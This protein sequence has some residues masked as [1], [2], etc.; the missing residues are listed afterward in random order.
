MV[1]LLL[2]EQT[3]SCL[4]SERFARL[5]QFSKK[6]HRMMESHFIWWPP[7]SQENNFDW[8]RGST[9]CVDPIADYFT[10]D[11]DILIY[12]RKARFQY[13]LQYVGAFKTW[14]NAART[15]SGSLARDVEAS[16]PS[17]LSWAKGRQSPL[18]LEV[19]SYV[20]QSVLDYRMNDTL[21]RMSAMSANETGHPFGLSA[22]GGYQI[23]ESSA[24]TCLPSVVNTRYD[25]ELSGGSGRH[26]TVS[27]ETKR[28]NQSTWTSV[29][30]SSNIFMQLQ[31][32]EFVGGS[33]IVVGT[34]SQYN[35]Q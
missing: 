5:V 13:P 8:S 18:V 6:A 7:G 30:V 23:P 20:Q 9:C 1:N 2:D 32:Q 16:H 31:P 19:P 4:G 14:I 24:Q 15:N 34:A 11:H 26:K 27:W 33:L 28:K 29:T 35:D 12:H 17:W 21:V 10:L 22:I 3:R 25:S